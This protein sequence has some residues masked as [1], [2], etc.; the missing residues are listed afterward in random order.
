[1]SNHY[2]RLNELNTRM[3]ISDYMVVDE[4]FSKDLVFYNKLKDL[5]AAISYLLMSEEARKAITLS[6][7]AHALCNGIQQ[8]YLND[9]LPPD[10]KIKML[11]DLIALNDGIK[12]Y[13]KHNNEFNVRL[14]TAG[15]RN[16]ITLTDLQQYALINQDKIA[17]LY[18]LQTRVNNLLLPLRENHGIEAMYT[19]QQSLA[20]VRIIY[21]NYVMLV[22]TMNGILKAK[23]GKK[24]PEDGFFKT[25]TGTE[26][27][28]LSKSEK[29]E[30]EE[31]KKCFDSGTT[32][33]L[34][35]I[36]RNVDDKVA[37]EEEYAKR[38]PARAGIR[39]FVKRIRDRYTEVM[40]RRRE[41]KEIR[42]LAKRQ[43]EAGTSANFSIQ[44]PI[45]ERGPFKA[46][47]PTEPSNRP[48]ANTQQQVAPSA[49]VTPQPNTVA[50][51]PAPPTQETA[52]RPPQIASSP[53]STTPATPAEQAVTTTSPALSDAP[54]QQTVQ[55]QAQHT[56]QATPTTPP[57]PL[58]PMIAGKRK[59]QA[60]I[61]KFVKEI[62]NRE[63]EQ[64][65]AGQQATKPL[66]P[67]EFNEQQ[68]KWTKKGRTP[69]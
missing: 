44:V 63:S 24:A 51:P 20:S 40:D 13:L 30:L 34:H 17:E 46:P 68:G 61:R 45:L 42:L 16:E 2:H 1:M 56:Q 8:V 36:K 39:G 21:G 65:K 53:A 18:M 25:P 43:L 28:P 27:R 67:E 14:E 10:I 26:K 58:T 3:P 57:K 60:N 6:P 49:K 9:K 33:I 31:I 37:E 66:T 29:A 69:Q 38:I 62:E 55:S 59:M 22:D 4:A 54:P 32:G 47:P 52:V 5:S 7:E 11:E 15:G 23:E 50:S 35:I 19:L 48:A 12:D 64:Q 41:K